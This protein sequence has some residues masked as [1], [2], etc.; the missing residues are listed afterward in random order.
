M[1]YNY[2]VIKESIKLQV[3][4]VLASTSFESDE[5]SANMDIEIRGLKIFMQYT[6]VRKKKT[7]VQKKVTPVQIKPHQ[8][9][10]FFN[11]EF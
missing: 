4:H 9:I 5:P 3:K 8:F 2:E 10:K 11:K 6:V 7:P 1:I